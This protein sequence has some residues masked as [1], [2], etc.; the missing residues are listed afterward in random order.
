MPWFERKAVL[1]LEPSVKVSMLPPLFHL[2]NG[3]FTLRCRYFFQDP[4]LCRPQTSVLVPPDQTTSFHIFV[5]SPKWFVRNL[6]SGLSSCHSS[7]NDR[8]VEFAIKAVQWFFHLSCGSLLLLIIRLATSPI[9]APFSCPVSC[10]NDAFEPLSFHIEMMDW[11]CS[12][13]EI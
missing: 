11:T 10:G 5:V 2:R 1:K 7:I 9:N 4:Y 6:F 3:F 13:L 8:F 12:K